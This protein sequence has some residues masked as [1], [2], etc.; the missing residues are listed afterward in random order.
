VNIAAKNLGCRLNQA[1]LQ[2]VISELQMRGHS[3]CGLDE[4]PD[5]A[6]VNTCVVTAVSEQKTRQLVSRALASV[7]PDGQVVVTGCF[8][9]NVERRGGCCMC[10]M[11]TNI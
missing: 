8:A 4:N 6:I 11:I 1:E 5:A 7:A 10:P 2:S 3:F 9:R